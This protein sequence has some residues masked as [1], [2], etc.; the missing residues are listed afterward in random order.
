MLKFLMKML[1]I[2][3]YLMK[4]IVYPEVLYKLSNKIE[5]NFYCNFFLFVLLTFYNNEYLILVKKGI[6]FPFVLN[7]YCKVASIKTG[8]ISILLDEVKYC[9]KLKDKS[10]EFIKRRTK[11]D[12]DFF[13]IYDYLMYIYKVSIFLLEIRWIDYS[14]WNKQKLLT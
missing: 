2:E 12:L 9:L 7:F 14:E 4:C 1:L 3:L 10:D 11:I 5:H 8:K 13:D 6:P